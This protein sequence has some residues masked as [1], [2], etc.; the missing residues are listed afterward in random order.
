VDRS[1]PK[2]QSKGSNAMPRSAFGRDANHHVIPGSSEL[3]PLQCTWRDC[4]REQYLGLPVCF[5]HAVIISGV[6]N[7][8]TLG[9]EPTIDALA[10]EP[11]YVYYLMV[12]PATV[13]IGTT[14]NLRA[15]IV[16]GL[17]SDLQYVVAI[18]R[19]GRDTERR[20]HQQFAGDRISRREEFRLSKRL[21]KHIEA[22]QPH[23]DELLTE[24]S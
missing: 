9:P 24:A 7:D 10:D 8:A 2:I 19:G 4:R 5:E 17:R 21:T 11:A 20:R 12:G 3:I 22:L 6:I 13:K 18:E 1:A 23:R 16:N 14:R 15:R